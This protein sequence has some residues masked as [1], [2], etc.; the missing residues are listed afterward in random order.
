VSFQE[1]QEVFR[2]SLGTDKIPFNFDSAWVSLY[3]GQKDGIH[4]LDYPQFAQLSKYPAL[5]GLLLNTEI[6]IALTAQ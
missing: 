4:V 1:F 5:A 6:S 3:L 2:A